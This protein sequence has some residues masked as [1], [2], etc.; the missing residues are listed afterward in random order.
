[1]PH[2]MFFG[3]KSVVFHFPWC[4]IQY[5]YRFHCL[6]GGNLFPWCVPVISAY[7]EPAWQRLILKSAFFP[8]QCAISVSVLGSQEWM[9]VALNWE[10][11]YCPF[12]LSTQTRMC[13]FSVFTDCC[14]VL[15]VPSVVSCPPLSSF[16][17]WIPCCGERGC[18]SGASFIKQT[19]DEFWS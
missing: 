8:F 15:W 4:Y 18:R 10:L 12:R 6:Q 16:M 9:C 11:N 19:Y 2:L 3:R 13:S 7:S 14:W 5:I 1:M 17:W